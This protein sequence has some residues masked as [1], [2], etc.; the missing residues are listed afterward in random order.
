ME[1]VCHWNGT[2]IPVSVQ[3]DTIVVIL[4]WMRHCEM[5][6]DWGIWSISYTT[7]LPAIN[8]TLILHRQQV[9]TACLAAS[10][11]HLQV[12]SIIKTCRGIKTII[13]NV[14]Y[15]SCCTRNWDLVPYTVQYSTHIIAFYWNY[16][17]Q[18]LLGGVVLCTYWT[19][20]ITFNCTS[21]THRQ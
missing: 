7:F 11:G 15:I 17:L 12:S 21:P 16:V 4:D 1:A 8:T 19:C 5:L 20:R 3:N 2:H 14:I 13:T 6:G 18:E 9:L 10:V